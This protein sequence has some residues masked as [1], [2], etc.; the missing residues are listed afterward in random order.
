MS[1]REGNTTSH[2]FLSKWMH[3]YAFEVLTTVWPASF[4]WTISAEWSQ[5]C[6]ACSDSGDVSNTYIT[7]VITRVTKRPDAS[8]GSIAKNYVH[9]AAMVGA[10]GHRHSQ[11]R[12]IFDH[13]QAKDGKRLK[14]SPGP[15]LP[16]AG[17]EIF[18]KP[19]PWG[20]CVLIFVLK[21]LVQGGEVHSLHGEGPQAPHRAIGSRQGSCQLLEFPTDAD[22][23][24]T[25][26]V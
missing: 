21:D 15:Y 24:S 9:L 1:L 23:E 25:G 3:D 26:I 2:V 16:G 7:C 13:D 12:D 6:K 4:M 10:T 14:S 20:F 8:T 17:R 18:E 5:L 22:T 19:D 11:R